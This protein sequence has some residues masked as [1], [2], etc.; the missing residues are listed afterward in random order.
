MGSTCSMSPTQ[1]RGDVSAKMRRGMGTMRGCIV[2]THICGRM[3]LRGGETR[4]GMGRKGKGG[5]G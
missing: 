5:G 3:M 1:A 2:Q 4:D